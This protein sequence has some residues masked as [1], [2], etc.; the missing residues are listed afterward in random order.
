MTKATSAVASQG[1]GGPINTPPNPPSPADA[2]TYKRY[3]TLL[4]KPF[5]WHTKRVFSGFPR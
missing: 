1:L 5:A 4:K 2:E 3:D